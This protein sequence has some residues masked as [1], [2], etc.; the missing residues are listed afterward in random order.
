LNTI[1]IT[2]GFG[3]IGSHT[4]LNLLERGENILII[5]SLVNS[6]I[7]VKSKIEFLS[8]LKSNSNGKLIFREG[9]I[10]DKDWLRDIFKEFKLLRKPINFVFHFAGLK[11]V[12]ESTQIP[13]E[14]WDTNVNGTINLLNIMKE[15]N[16]FNIIFSSSAMVYKQNPNK[17]FK[18][19]SELNPSNPYAFTKFTIEKILQNLSISEP[20]KWRIANL[21]YFNPVGAHSSGLLGEYPKGMSSNLFPAI[22]NSLIHNKKE[23]LIFGNN[24][25]T[26]DGTCIRDFIHIMD[27]A[28]AHIAASNLLIKENPQIITLNIGTGIGTSVLNIIKTFEKVNKCSIKYKFSPRRAGDVPYI[29]ADNEYA[30]K[31]LNWSPQKDT[32]DICKDS[33]NWLQKIKP[34]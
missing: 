20:K 26:P 12:E 6:T 5:D 2:G 14:Y 33:W 18:E 30:I 3:Y 29:V 10:R 34:T 31:K 4:C 23:L 15:Y 28:R 11:S 13:L 9:D 27:L 7:K 1:L 32:I 21:R 25:P 22:L 24:W 8:S 19:N 16:C 17:S